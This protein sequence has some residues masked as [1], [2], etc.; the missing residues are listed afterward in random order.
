MDRVWIYLFFPLFF[1]ERNRNRLCCFQRDINIYTL[2]T[3]VFETV[4]ISE[5]EEAITA[6]SCD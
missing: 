6:L 1:K 3:D 2:K 5:L 4:D